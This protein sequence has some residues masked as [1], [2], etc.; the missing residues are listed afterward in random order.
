MVAAMTHA[1]I[2][3]LLDKAAATGL[4]HPELTVRISPLGD[5]VQLAFRA[6]RGTR[7]YHHDQ[8][9]S[10]R[11]IE[12]ARLGLDVLAMGLDLI[13]RALPDMRD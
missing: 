10:R 11:Q 9:F 8:S 7:V 1:D 6:V 3:A 5:D 13:T 12:A 4:E 2:L